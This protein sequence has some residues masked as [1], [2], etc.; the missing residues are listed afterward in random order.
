MT[1]KLSLVLVLA[2][3]ALAS[4]SLTV[5][6]SPA[7]Q[8]VNTFD[9]NGALFDVQVNNWDEHISG[10]EISCHAV[11]AYLNNFGQRWAHPIDAQIN[12]CNS[13]RSGNC[14]TW[15]AAIPAPADAS[16]VIEAA[17]YCQHNNGPKIWAQGTGN[18]LFQSAN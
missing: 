5:T 10:Q 7:R 18:I 15:F 11:Y 12:S 14:N 3:A 4:A 16:Q 9:S 6:A 2:A 8:S 17:A 13:G 1:S